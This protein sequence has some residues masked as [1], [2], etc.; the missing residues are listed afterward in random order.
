MKKIMCIII[1]VISAAAAVLCIGMLIVNHKAS[2]LSD[3]V[4]VP[5]D[6]YGNYP[7][8]QETFCYAYNPDD[9][10][11]LSGAADY[12]SV[13]YIK[14]CS[15]TSY[16]NV[17]ADGFKIRGNPFTN[18]EIEIYRNIKGELDTDKAVPFLMYGGVSIDKKFLSNPTPFPPK[19]RC[20]IMYSRLGEDNRLYISKTFTLD[21]ADR[22]ECLN[23]AE[24]GRDYELLNECI[25][26]YENQ[27]IPSFIN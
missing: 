9:K 6:E 8:A 14:E 18:F 22:S 21:A 16:Q 12:I 10:R 26:A 17:K 15:G 23:M 13:A 1:S 25:D 7:K 4:I 2:V 3:G 24:N 19:G 20:C 11:E 5:F 27:M